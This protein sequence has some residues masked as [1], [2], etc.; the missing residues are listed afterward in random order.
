MCAR[1]SPARLRITSYNVC[2]TK[3]LRDA[4]T[5]EISRSQVWQWLKHGISTS[6]GTAIT[7]DRVR[8]TIAEEVAKLRG[9]ESGGGDDRALAAKLF[10]Q[11]MT[12]ATFAEWLTVVAYDYIDRN[13]FV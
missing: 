6:D 9:T 4:A 3:L 10:E 5:A 7:A 8:V 2:Y 1:S 11:M 12:D 13:N